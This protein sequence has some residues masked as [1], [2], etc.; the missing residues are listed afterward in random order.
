M[1]KYIVSIYSKCLGAALLMSNYNACFHGE[2]RN[3]IMCGYILLYGAL[4]W[5]HE[6]YGAIIRDSNIEYQSLYP[7]PICSKLMMSLVND[8]L[9]FTLSDR[10][11]C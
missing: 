3:N 8:S 2:T 4:V 5:N 7:G 11:T 1:K 10:Q 6:E 9:K